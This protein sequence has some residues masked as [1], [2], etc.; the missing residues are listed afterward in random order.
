NRAGMPT[1]VSKG[2][3]FRKNKLHGRKKFSS[4]KVRQAASELVA[5]LGGAHFR[6]GD[7]NVGIKGHGSDSF[8]LFCRVRCLSFRYRADRRFTRPTITPLNVPRLTFN[9]GA[10]NT[11]LSV[12]TPRTIGLRRS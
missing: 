12:V 5:H 3:R 6:I 11:S 4:C 2:G 8:Q 7:G 9:T 10:D 1:S